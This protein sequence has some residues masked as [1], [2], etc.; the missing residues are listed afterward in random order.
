MELQAVGVLRPQDPVHLPDDLY[1]ERIRK[2]YV[3][4]YD[5]PRGKGG[6]VGNIWRLDL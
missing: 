6:G 1:L 4:Q 2:R 5:G 3:L